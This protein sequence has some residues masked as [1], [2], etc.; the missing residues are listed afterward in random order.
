MEDKLENIT[1]AVETV[2]KPLPKTET[3]SQSVL[4]HQRAW[5]STSLGEL[6]TCPRRYYYRIVLGYVPKG[7]SAHLTFGLIYH[8]ALELYDHRKAE[9]MSH[10]D[11]MI[12][13]VGHVLERTWDNALGRP[14]A[15]DNN[16]KTRD[17][18]LRTVVWYLE[19][20]ADDPATTLIL[21]DGKPAV[22]LSF[23]FEPGLQSSIDGRDYILCGHLDR[24]VEFNEGYWNVDRKTTKYSLDDS[25][26]GKYSPD[27][28][29][30]MYSVAGT[31]ILDKPLKGIIIDAAQV[32]VTF[33]RYQRYLVHRHQAV[34]TEWLNDTAHWLRIAEHFALSNYW[35][36]NDKACLMYYS[37]SDPVYSGCP[38]RSV[39]AVIPALRKKH[40]DAYFDKA[41]WDPLIVRGDVH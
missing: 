8:S 32:G 21:H 11:A 20:F 35:P 2:D 15:S 39:C 24:V 40:L 16:L 14:W 31:L 25:Y 27:N 17:S 26:A 36:M 23:R 38:Y 30:S 6:K 7:Q 13:A 37:A 19:K 12:E 33:S 10:D 4:G 18:L 1:V 22:E 28:Q 5:D 41:V 9:G 34:L 3:F 29:M